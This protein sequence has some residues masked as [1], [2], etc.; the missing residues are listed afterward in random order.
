MFGATELFLRDCIGVS[1]YHRN[2]GSFRKLPLCSASVVHGWFVCMCYTVVC[3]K[4]LCTFP[5]LNCVELYHIYIGQ[6]ATTET[7]PPVRETS[8]GGEGEERGD[9]GGG[10]GGGGGEGEGEEEMFFDAHEMSAEEWAKTTRAEFMESSPGSER[11]DGSATA[12]DEDGPPF[13]GR[14]MEEVSFHFL[15]FVFSA[16]AAALIHT[17]CTLG[18]NNFSS[19]FSQIVL[20]LYEEI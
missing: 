12:A 15:K 13:N 7:A 5:D 16:S 9:G 17:L 11:T 6:L 3:V 8:E 10:G 1:M 4:Y 18:R 19:L 14:S 20:N 2:V